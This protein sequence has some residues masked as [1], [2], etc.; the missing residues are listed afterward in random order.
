MR[1]ANYD[2]RS[3]IAVMSADGSDHVVDVE[4]ASRG[5][6]PS[7]PM[8][9]SD[10]ANHGALAGI[11][12]AANPTDWPVLQPELLRAPVPR[13]P[14]G[15][16]VALNYRQHA[17]ES[18]LTLP[19]EPHLFGKMENCVCGPYD[20]IIVPAGRDMVDYEAELVIVFG[21]T[22]KQAT[23]ADA[24]GFLAGV[25]CGQDI[26]DRGEQFRQPV[27][28]FTIAKTYDTFGP[29]GPFLVT[30]DELPDPDA[31]ELEGRVSGTVM[32]HSNTS[33]LIFDVPALVEWLSRFITFQP[34]D[35]VWTGTP[36]GVG[37]AQTPPRFLRAGDVVETE[38][39]GIGLMRN[40]VVEQ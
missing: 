38:I 33:D 40:P 17:I 1:L 20:E 24:W 8:V 31:L 29:I 21:R 3:S 23:A 34:G 32:Q 13:P 15:F 26:S 10:L 25:T 14:K 30:P 37:E 22:C 19:T 28:Q 2:G 5:A 9:L 39:A 16:G 6:L 11:A 36:S 27:R 7:D 4:S 18:G 35:L 12:G